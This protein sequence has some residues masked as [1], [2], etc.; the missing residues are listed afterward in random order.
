MLALAHDRDNGEGAIWTRP[1]GKGRIIVSGYGSLFTN[2]AD[3]PL[4]TTRVC[5][6]TSSAPMWVGAA[7]ADPSS[8][9][10]VLFDDVHQGLGASYDPDK[11]YKDP[12]LY[13]SLA[14]LVALWFVWVLGATRLRLT[15]AA[16]LDAARGG[17]HSGRWQFSVA[18]GAELRGR[19]A[20]TGSFLQARSGE[21]RRCYRRASAVGAAGAQCAHRAGRSA[22]DSPMAHRCS[23]R[24]AR[25]F[26]DLHNLLVRLDRQMAT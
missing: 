24:A 23:I 2:R 6:R 20:A 4:R 16:S 1:L 25:A 21:S 18:G 5:S 26:R 13:L 7:A 14:I 12:R 3:R 11:F 22:A 19:S 10:A 15:I 9:G 17:A 8:Q